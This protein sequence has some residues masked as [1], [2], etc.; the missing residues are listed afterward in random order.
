[1][2]GNLTFAVCRQRERLERLRLAFTANNKYMKI[3]QNNSHVY[4]YHETIYRPCLR[5]D[6]R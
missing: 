1:M 6:K 4:D 2:K 3:V 5:N